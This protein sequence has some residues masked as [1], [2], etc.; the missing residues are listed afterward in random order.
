MHPFGY[1][2][3]RYLEGC[4]FVYYCLKNVWQKFGSKE[5]SR[6]FALPFEKRVADKAKSSTER[7]VVK[8]WVLKNF[9]NFFKKVWRLQNNAYLCNPVRKTGP[10][11]RKIWSLFLRFF[12]KGEWGRRE[13][14]DGNDW[15]TKEAWQRKTQKE[16]RRQQVHWK[17]WKLYKKQVPRKIQ[18]IEKR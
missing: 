13:L 12:A 3:I 16:T 6:T 7:L 18:F 10:W 11:K 8:R 5:K 14:P 15:Q 4:I 17:D 9:Q 1:Q 2:I